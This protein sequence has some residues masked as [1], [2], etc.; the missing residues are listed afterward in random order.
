MSGT[1]VE[2]STTPATTIAHSAL[3]FWALF[4]ALCVAVLCQALDNTIISTAIPKI[5]DDFNSLTDI[6]EDL[7]PSMK[8]IC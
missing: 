2:I 3:Q 6:G 5:T 1:K 4:F 7:K 8:D